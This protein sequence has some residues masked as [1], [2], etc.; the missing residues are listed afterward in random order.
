MNGKEA[1]FPNIPMGWKTLFLRR[2]REKLLLSGDTSEIGS[3]SLL[4][5]MKTPSSSSFYLFSPKKINKCFSR[6]AKTRSQMA[7]RPLLFGDP[8]PKVFC[9]AHIHYCP[10]VGRP[11]APRF[12][13]C[14]RDKGRRRRKGHDDMMTFGDRRQAF[15]R[16]PPLT[17]NQ[18]PMCVCSLLA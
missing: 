16:L 9:V 12:Q 15:S 1:R 7:K 17:D 2:R 6:P 8:A 5:L 14:Y 18:A 4:A 3:L 11:F 10:K 13:C